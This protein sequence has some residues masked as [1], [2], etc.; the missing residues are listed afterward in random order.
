MGSA[1]QRMMQSFDGTKALTDMV[2]VV[3]VDA[4]DSNDVCA[5]TLE[6]SY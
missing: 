3:V 5:W 2:V 1:H 6:S 4:L